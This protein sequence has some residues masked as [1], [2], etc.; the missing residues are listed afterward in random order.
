[1]ENKLHYEKHGNVVIDFPKM[2]Y[3][4]SIWRFH[5]IYLYNWCEMKIN[6]FYTSYF[7]YQGKHFHE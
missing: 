4:V 2:L 3:Y 1:M 6:L 7:L 5:V